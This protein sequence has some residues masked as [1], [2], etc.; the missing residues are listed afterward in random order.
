MLSCFAQFPQGLPAI[1]D[2]GAVSPEVAPISSMVNNSSVVA[3]PNPP[4]GATNI[5][6]PLGPI[7]NWPT[8]NI[9]SHPSD[10]TQTAPGAIPTEWVPDGTVFP[11]N[12]VTLPSAATPP[13]SMFPTGDS[14]MYSPSVFSGD[15][16]VVSI[17]NSPSIDPSGVYTGDPI[18][19]TMPIV[20]T[21]NKTNE[22]AV[23]FPS[24]NYSSIESTPTNPKSI[25]S[26]NS[27]RASPIFIEATFVPVFIT[28]S[29]G[30]DSFVQHMFNIF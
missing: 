25:F 11:P 18:K 10:I 29:D 19:A 16:P 3:A 28:P 12:A 24:Q 26:S 2:N 21:S 5:G 22:L 20:D 1:D 6:A 4:P 30:L 15:Q 14:A 9:A 7:T 8:T 27:N 13:L 23:G 17:P